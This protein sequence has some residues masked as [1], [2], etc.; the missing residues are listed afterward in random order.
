MTDTEYIAA[1]TKAVST[2]GRSGKPSD[3]FWSKVD[4]SP[5]LGPHGRCWEWRGS[6]RGAGYGTIGMYAFTGSRN[7]IGAHV[8]SYELVHGP[9]PEGKDVLHH[10]DNPPCVN[11]D[12]L[13]AGT[14]KQNIHDAQNKGRFPV[15]K[16]VE[17][18]YQR[19][20]RLNPEQ[21]AV[22]RTAR[23]SKGAS[24][25][26][27][28]EMM[29]RDFSYY[30]LM[31]N[32]KRGLTVEQY[33]F[34]LR[35][36]ELDEQILGVTP[37]QFYDSG[38]VGVKRGPQQHAKPY[39]RV[40]AKL[41][42][43]SHRPP[44]IWSQFANPRTDVFRADLIQTALKATFKQMGVIVQESGVP[45]HRLRPLLNGHLTYD[46]KAFLARIIEYAGLNPAQIVLRPTVIPY[47]FRH[48]GDGMKSL[49][50]AS[51]LRDAVVSANKSQAE[52]LATAQISRHQ[53]LQTLDGKC[54]KLPILQ[55][56]ANAVGVNMAQL[57]EQQAESVA[58]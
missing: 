36:L 16:Y 22:I 32:G 12:D 1:L 42:V 40:R 20:V 35:F 2:D 46:N 45:R 18:H 30:S 56:V 6:H 31:E 51:L 15:R 33:H 52:L 38:K 54:V 8:I 25:Y 7:P 9:V 50:N 39:S 14:A 19:R 44:L 58:A 17:I 10:C 47:W 43:P 21:L 34:V 26:D 27:M 48:L 24:I 3:R 53:L 49:Y 28:A 41:F 11:P 57:F 37:D 4:K 29:D 23:K 13:W 55:A 5:G